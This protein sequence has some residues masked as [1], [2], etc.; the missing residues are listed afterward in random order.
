LLAFLFSSC[1][2]STTDS[3][4]TDTNFLGSP[5]NAHLT[6]RFIPKDWIE[7][8]GFIFGAEKE[9]IDS[10]SVAEMLKNFSPNTPSFNTVAEN[11]TN[12]GVDLSKNWLISGSYTD[13]S[14][15]ASFYLKASHT[16]QIKALLDANKIK[17]TIDLDGITAYLVDEKLAEHHFIIHSQD[18]LLLLKTFGDL[19]SAKKVLKE[20]VYES[21]EA[22]VSEFN[23][24]FGNR[25]NDLDIQ[26]NGNNEISKLIHLPILADVEKTFSGFISLNVNENNLDLSVEPTNKDF[27]LENVLMPFDKKIGSKASIQALINF[28]ELKTQLEKYAYLDDINYE[29]K[30]AKLDYNKVQNLCKG[31]IILNYNGIKTSQTKSTSYV[32]DE[33]FNQKEVVKYINTESYDFAGYI[34]SKNA[35]GIKKILTDNQLITETKKGIYEPII[36]SKSTLQ[37]TADGL[38]IGQLLD[39]KNSTETVK[40]YAQIK[41]KNLL[42]MLGINQK[43]VQLILVKDA[44]LTISKA[45]KIQLNINFDGKKYEYL[46][47]VWQIFE[48][49]TN[50]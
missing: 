3:E 41:D 32:F 26:I 35:A 27:I 13:S 22:F 46:A 30:K 40:L 29:L 39:D 44:D 12:L 24:T 7:K 9:K 16:D 48:P 14:K 4:T 50:I 8:Q 47:K 23:Q 21:K 20:C 38:K 37:F 15:Y 18:H 43:I 31:L 17:E 1:K 28:G 42:S 49:Q 45:N 33:E 2:E 5:K 25:R 11:I 36:G 34:A 10:F 19:E 6:L